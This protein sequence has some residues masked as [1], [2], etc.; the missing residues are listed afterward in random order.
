[1]PGYLVDD[2]A[3]Y[4]AHSLA[5]KDENIRRRY[6]IRT[7]ARESFRMQNDDQLRRAMLVRARTVATP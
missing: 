4:S 2:T 5:A 6:A 3:N 1:M 7:A